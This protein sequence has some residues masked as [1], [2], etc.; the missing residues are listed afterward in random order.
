MKINS[1]HSNNFISHNPLVSVV[2]VSWNRKS[3]VA[4]TLNEYR[5]QT[6]ENFEIIVVDNNSADGTQELVKTE[7]PEVRLFALSEN[8]G[9]H[10]FNI[11]MKNAKGEIIVISDDDCH[12][13][14]DGIKKYVDKFKSNNNLCIA[15]CRMIYYPLG[16][17]YNW[18]PKKIKDITKSYD[19]HYFY[20]AGAGLRKSLLETI[21]YFDEDFFISMSEVDLSTRAIGAGYDVKYFPDITVYHKHYDK[22][23]RNKDKVNKF[24]YYSSINIIFYYW[25]YF[26]FHVAFGR[27]IVRIPFDF[28]WTLLKSKSIILPFK[29][30]KGIITGFNGNLKKRK[31]IQKQYV[32]KALGYQSEI[33]NLY[34]FVRNKIKY[35]IK[36]K[37]TI[38]D[39]LKN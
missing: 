35:I 25:K 37:K 8:T 20:N 31:A 14:H 27:S 18:Y 15:A 11:G 32:K 9:Y 28:F 19:S 29:I 13:E 16:I 3:D 1:E 23:K 24:L 6:Y 34:T 21:G 22:N 39:T 26:P 36:R 10:A 12:L 17:E 2:V 5:K 7:Y 33:G 30:L 4:H 38:K